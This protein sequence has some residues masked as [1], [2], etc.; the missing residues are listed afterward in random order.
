ML[1]IRTGGLAFCHGMTWDDGLV[2]VVIILWQ[3]VHMNLMI[4]LFN[5]HKQLFATILN[6]S[7]CRV[8]QHLLHTRQKTIFICPTST[9]VMHQN[10]KILPGALVLRILLA[11]KCSLVYFG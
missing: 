7:I 2:C 11:V 9:E 6:R 8:Y 10:C 1:E 4:Y 3:Y 5:Q